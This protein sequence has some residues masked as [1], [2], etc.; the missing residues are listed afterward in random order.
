MKIIPLFLR[1]NLKNPLTYNFGAIYPIK[2]GE[3]ELSIKS[4]AVSFEQ[5]S[6][7]NPI[8]PNLDNF[9]RVSCNYVETIL[10][11]SSQT[12]SLTSESVL[13]ILH[14]KLRPGEKKLFDFSNRDYFF[15]SSPSEKFQC[16][17]ENSD[18]SSLEETIKMHLN[19]DILILFRRRN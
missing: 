3:W 9:I 14:V 17:I 19:V 4:V 13:E 18:G 16:N 11:D 8:P 10:L 1:G 12:Q 5:P 6:G 7:T 15:V 2:S